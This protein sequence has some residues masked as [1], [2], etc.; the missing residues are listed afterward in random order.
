MTIMRSVVTAR[1]V[2]GANTIAHTGR[3]NLSTLLDSVQLV[4]SVEQGFQGQG[5]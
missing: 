3:T 1:V 2:T 4:T 5:G